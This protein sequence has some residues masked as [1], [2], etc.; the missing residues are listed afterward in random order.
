MTEPEPGVKKEDWDTNEKTRSRP[1]YHQGQNNNRYQEGKRQP[2]RIT[3][4]RYT[5][6]GECPELEGSYL[7][8][9]T[10][11]RADIYETFICIM[12]GYVARK[13]AKRDGIKMIVSDLQIPTLEKPEDL[14]STA[15][16]V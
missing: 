3:T 1:K 10:G 6:N 12:S 7:D 14:D 16:D 2:D 11:Y 4:P 5:F 9:S 15:D 8:F 13:Y